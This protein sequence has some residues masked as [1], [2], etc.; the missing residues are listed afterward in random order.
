M[1]ID[2]LTIF[3]DMFAGPLQTSILARAQAQGVVVIR[4]HDIRAFSTDKHRSVDDSP[5]GGGAGM[6]MRAEPVVAAIESVAPITVDAVLPTRILLCPQGKPFTQAIA[7]ELS[8]KSHLVLVCP[9][10]EGIDERVREG[11]IDLEISIGDYVLTGG[12]LPALVLIDTV[13]RLLPGVLGN[14]ESLAEESFSQGLLEYPHYT[15]PAEFR[16]RRVPEILQ[17]GDHGA[18]AK[19]RAD[20]AR[21]RTLDR[22]PD[23]INRGEPLSA[24]AEIPPG[25]S[26][27]KDARG[28]KKESL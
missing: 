15:R 16:G 8:A 5:Y 21:A 12:E 6:V 14:P 1:H 28:Q 20:M 23:L 10:Y 17:G 9:R 11:W 7:R 22:R 25:S 2:I 26:C 13:V 19:W 27:R 18:I 24:S 3:P 4:T